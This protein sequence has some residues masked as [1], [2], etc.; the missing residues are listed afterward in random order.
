MHIIAIGYAGVFLYT[1][2]LMMPLSLPIPRCCR[3]L[4][5]SLLVALPCSG[6]AEMPREDGPVG[7]GAKSYPGEKEWQEQGGELPPWPE[8][9]R[10]IELDIDTGARGYRLYID[11]QSLAV[12]ED[13]VA[14]FTSVMISPTGV[15]NVSYEGLHCGKQ[16]HRRFAYGANEIWH[17]LP[18]S[19]WSRLTKDGVNRYRWIL[20]HH[21][22][23]N[24][25]ES[26][27]DAA[28]ILRRLRSSQLWIGN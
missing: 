15:W 11:P 24:P 18:N 12:G 16:E 5:L 6:F 1:A 7:F 28:D 9:N 14:R 4:C 17:E 3:I 27:K 13:H 25:T 21:Y 26:R 2:Q 23:C 19:S 20:Y 8:L 22:M 10:L